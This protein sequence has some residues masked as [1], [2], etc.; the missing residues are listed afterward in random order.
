MAA[1]E[2]TQAVFLLEKEN[3]RW[4]Y[5]GFGIVHAGVVTLK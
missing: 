2:Y 4:K 3:K 1:C 5:L